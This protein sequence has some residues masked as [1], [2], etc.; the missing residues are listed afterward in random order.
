VLQE[1]QAPKGPEVASW[2]TV[3]DGATVLAVAVNPYTAQVIKFVDKESTTFA[4]AKKIHGT[5][6]IGDVGGRLIE[7]AAGLGIVLV[8]TGLYLHWPRGSQAWLA[9]LV[10]DMRASGRKFWKSMHSSIGLWLS[11]VLVLFLLTGLSWTGIWGA[12]FVQPWSSFPAQKWDNVPTSDTTHASLNSPGL[13]DV[14]WGLEQTPLPVSGSD[15][16]TPGVPAGQAVNLDGVNALAQTLGFAGQYHINVPQDATGVYTVSADT[17]SGDLRVP[18]QDRTV[19]VDRYT[20]K[21]LVDVRFADYPVL[22]KAMAVGVALHQGDMGAWNALTNMAFCLAIAF[23][24]VSGVVMW[25]M[26]RPA[27]LSRLGAPVI[28]ANAVLWKGG[29]V[30]MLLVALAFPL[31]GAVLLAAL[32]LDFLVISRLPSLKSAVG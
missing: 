16:G 9:A 27:G 28:P 12:K 26:R 11:V 14:P 31:T 10:P 29:M 32:L 30:A 17:M 2:F 15:S 19:H 1:Y 22:A 21:V 24:C 5:L 8:I 20:G 6:L 18:T 7:V 25:W 4:W 13:N 23:L 3:K